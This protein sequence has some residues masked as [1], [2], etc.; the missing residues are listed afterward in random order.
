MALTPSPTTSVASPL[1]ARVPLA[2]V[3]LSPT[4]GT[5]GHEVPAAFGFGFGFGLGLGFGFGFGFGL[6][7][8]VE[9]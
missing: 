2:R 1:G 4:D 8:R 9:G 6:R 3:M 7:A 5:L